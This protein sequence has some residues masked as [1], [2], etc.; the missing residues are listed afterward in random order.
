MVEALHVLLATADFPERSQIL[1][2]K[3]VNALKYYA[4]RG[5]AGRARNPNK[6]HHVAATSR[7]V[8]P[9]QNTLPT[10]SRKACDFGTCASLQTV[11]DRSVTCGYSRC[12][13]LGTFALGLL[14]QTLRWSYRSKMRKSGFRV[15]HTY[16]RGSLLWWSDF[17][18]RV[19]TTNDVVQDDGERHELADTAVLRIGAKWEAL[20][21]ADLIN[22]LNRDTS[23]YAAELGLR[24]RKHMTRDECQAL[25]FGTGYLDFRSVR[26]LR[27]FAKRYLLNSFDI[28]ARI[29]R[30]CEKPIDRFFIIR[31]L[32]AHYSP[33]AERAYYRLLRTQYNFHRMRA[34]G[35]FL[36]AVDGRSGNMRIIDFINAFLKAERAMFKAASK[37]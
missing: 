12:T 9:Y 37:F 17:V 31:N 35:E 34:P 21:Q 14:A 16:F 24:L 18:I 26:E 27:A 7:N 3:S 5:T 29:P 11:C 4:H 8:P 19:A 6:T 33:Y 13:L 22:C 1:P 2:T 32:V 28:F 10:H 30:D 23:K 20:V 15:D 25:L 36:L